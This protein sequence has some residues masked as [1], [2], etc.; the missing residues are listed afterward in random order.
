MTG[1]KC[2]YKYH[3]RCFWHLWTMSVSCRNI[4]QDTSDRNEIGIF[5][6]LLGGCNGCTHKQA[7][8]KSALFGKSELVHCTRNLQLSRPDL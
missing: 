8:G 5:K 3:M 1:C 2:Q 4:A 6:F 7:V